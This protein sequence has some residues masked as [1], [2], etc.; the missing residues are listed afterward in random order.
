MRPYRLLISCYLKEGES[1]MSIKPHGTF[2][3]PARPTEFVVGRHLV[4]GVAPG[5]MIDT[6][7]AFDKAFGSNT[8]S[9]MPAHDVW[10]GD[11][12]VELN[13]QDLF[14]A[15][16]LGGP[17]ALTDIADVC[18]L[19]VL[20]IQGAQDILIDRMANIFFA[21]DCRGRKQVIFLY[22]SGNS[23]SLDISYFGVSSNWRVD[24]R[25]Y[26]FAPG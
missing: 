16:T 8:Y 7:L 26:R 5:L 1:H 10:C 24:S 15:L 4:S 20:N 14:A 22:G 25:V 2:S 9:A 19:L 18:A 6:S 21:L 12:E 3:I 13:N 23:W 17:D 11:L